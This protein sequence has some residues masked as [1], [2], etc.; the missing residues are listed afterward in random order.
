MRVAQRLLWVSVIWVAGCGGPGGSQPDASVLPAPDAGSG[1]DASVELPDAS[2]EPSPDAGIPAPSE[3]MPDANAVGGP[4][5]L[6]SHGTRPFLSPA[7]IDEVLQSGFSL[8]REFFVADWVPAPSGA[9][10]NLDGLGPLLN[11]ASCVACHPASGRPRALRPDG[12]VD[13]GILFR[14]AGPSGP[15]PVYG[16]QLQPFG[17]AGVPGE[18]RVTWQSDGGS[19]AFQL[20]PEAT[21]GPL[22][23]TTHALPRL[24]PHLAGMGLLEAVSDETL[25][26]LEDP[27][28]LD[29][30]GISGRAAR[31]PNDGGIGRFGWKAVHATLDDQTAAAFAGDLGI[32][33]PGHPD[34]CTALQPSCRAMPNGGS[35]EIARGD[36]ETVSVFMR[37]LGVPAA[38]R[39]EDDPVV[40]RGHALFE[41]VGCA[42]C[43][44]QTLVTAADAATP[45]LRSVTFQPYTDLLLHDMGPGLA[46]PF[47]EGVAGPAEWRTP[48]LWG[49]GLVEESPDAR[50][51]HDGRARTLLEAIRWHGGEAESAR[52]R[53]DALSAEDAAALMA[54]LRSL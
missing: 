34:D 54:F 4:L 26:A 17:I 15:D 8:G 38:R 20:A 9:R 27:Q 19:L 39:S 49:L 22:A 2:V 11:A 16:G 21:W 36:L 50:F 45:R 41:H 43:H 10:P 40:R 6:G 12:E 53:F 24:S 28:D 48:P 18:G 31:L 25:L 5:T 14:L 51:L 35:P 29:G 52:V 13:I 3:P 42:S 23:P 44:R 32:T 47:G 30:D 46:D 37:L 1:A 33:S 7:P